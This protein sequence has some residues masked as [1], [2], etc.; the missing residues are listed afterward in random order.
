[1][2]RTASE[3]NLWAPLNEAVDQAKQL[4]KRAQKIA[5]QTADEVRSRSE[6]AIH[7][8]QQRSERTLKLVRKNFAHAQKAIEDQTDQLAKLLE[9]V[10][11]QLKPVEEQLQKGVER[12]A[13]SL[14]IATESDLDALRRKFASLEKR[15]AELAKESRAA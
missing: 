4:N 9:S 7:A 5:K 2:S 15:V 11:R 14:N 8:A 13:H 12:L 1:M 6:A 10:R 3:T